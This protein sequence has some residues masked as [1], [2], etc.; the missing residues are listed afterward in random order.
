MG[1]LAKLIGRPSQSD[2]AQMVMASIQAQGERRLLSYVPDQFALILSGGDANV[3]H[4]QNGF[5][6]YYAAP[7]RHR[8]AV[9]ERWARVWFAS[10]MTLPKTFDEA[11]PNLLPRIRERA[12]YELLQLRTKLGGQ[13]AP[14]APFLPVA[15]HLAVGL[16]LDLEES[17]VEGARS[18]LDEWHVTLE[19]ALKVARDNL[20]KRSNEDFESPAP[21]VYVSP[22]Q[23]N[24]DC[25][26]LY[27]HDLIWQLEVKGQ[28]IAMVPNR[29]TLIVTGS[30]DENGLETM[31][32]LAEEA[33]ERPRFMTGV[34]VRLDG[35]TWVDFLPPAGHPHHK[36]FRSLEL[37]SLARDSNEQKM[38]LDEHHQKSGQDLFVALFD[39]ME[40]KTTGE[41]SS[42]CVWSKT[43]ASLL[44]KTER[45][46]FFD[47]ALPKNNQ[48]LGVAAWDRV[49]AVAGDLL[50]PQGLFPERYR[51][52]SSPTPE[53][54]AAMQL[55][56]N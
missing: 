15:G 1:I 31:A 33:W 52:D 37:R 12:Y 50:K 55:T 44:P 30:G 2:F 11:K 42:F 16:A 17:I 40:N 8:K 5:E 45:I 24:H 22:W 49:V 29:D 46:A 9:V 6:E 26:R 3:L 27:L 53:Q 21:G 13:K 20:W 32:E 43:V 4:L 38:I 54:L 7:R 14:D 48:V 35:S 23:D 56:E 36:L 41:L 39:V 28:H 25:S 10:Q 19:E 47:P 18:Q 51:V 34:A